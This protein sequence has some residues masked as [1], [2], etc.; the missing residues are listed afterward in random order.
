MEPGVSLPSSQENDSSL[1][2]A[3]GTSTWGPV[4]FFLKIHVNIISLFQPKSLWQ[5]DIR[6]TTYFIIRLQ[7]S[8]PNFITM[9]ISYLLQQVANLISSPALSYYII[10]SLVEIN[11]IQVPYRWINQDPRNHRCLFTSAY[12]AREDSR[13]LGSSKALP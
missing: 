5:N 4:L 10:V 11:I 9:D 8:A 6:I 12:G 1:C 3:P 2:L 7:K 13:S